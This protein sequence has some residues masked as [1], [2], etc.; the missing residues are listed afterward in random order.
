M[1]FA[2]APRS[3]VRRAPDLDGAAWA[4]AAIH[5]GSQGY[6]DPIAYQ[7]FD[8]RTTSAT[9]IACWVNGGVLPKL[10]AA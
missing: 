6:C 10:G 7:R 2:T 9:L 8:W 3:F 4:A 5:Y 1:N